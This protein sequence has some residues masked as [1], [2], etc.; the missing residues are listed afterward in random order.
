VESSHGRRSRPVPCS[1]NARRSAGPYALRGEPIGACDARREAVLV[2]RSCRLPW[3]RRGGRPAGRGP[4]SNCSNPPRLWEDI[5]RDARIGPGEHSATPRATAP[6]SET[7]APFWLSSPFPIGSTMRP[8]GR[9]DDPAPVPP[10]ELGRDPPR[11][12]AGMGEREPDDPL[13]DDR[14]ELSGIRGRRRSRGRS[15]CLRRHG[16]N[17]R[18]GTVTSAVAN[19]DKAA[20][21]SPRRA[22]TPVRWR[23]Q[24]ARFRR[25]AST[26]RRAQPGS[27]RSR[28][29]KIKESRHYF[30]FFDPPQADRRGSLTSRRSNADRGG[31]IYCPSFVGSSAP[32]G[33][34]ARVGTSRADAWAPSA[35]W[36]S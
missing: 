7:V 31:F 13:L 15:I 14:R 17:T 36:P 5:R 11:P 21:K 32:P 20:W 22:H 3:S 4:T 23:V 25:R 1:R 19:G 30:D 2:L 33:S 26:R 16:L 18:R 8:V 10:R 12:Q 9:D 6:L 27:S 35:E 24:K 34:P 29:T 28:A